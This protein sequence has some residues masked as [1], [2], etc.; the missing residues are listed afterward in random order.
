ML[1]LLTLA[2]A[3]LPASFD[4]GMPHT[5]PA[6]VLRPIAQSTGDKRAIA[7]ISTWLK[8]YRKGK[9]DLSTT[10][11]PRMG[12]RGPRRPGPG[13]R[14]NVPQGP[15][16]DD[17]LIVKHKLLP[18][19]HIRGMSYLI[20][21]DVLCR[22]AR[23]LDNVAAARAVL[24][25]AAVGLDTRVKYS[26]KM[27]PT[28]VRRVGESQLRR[29]RS[30]EVIAYLA[31]A[32]A[33]NPGGSG[34]YKTAM[35]AAALRA[36]GVKRSSVHRSVIVEQLKST[37]P[38]VRAAAANALGR[39]AEAYSIKPL[40]E[41]LPREGHPTVIIEILAAI[42]MIRTPL[43]ESSV[44]LV[45]MQMA[46][47]EAGRALGRADTWR[48]DLA[49]VDFLEKYRY[50]DSIPLLIQFLERWDKDPHKVKSGR[51]S[52]RLRFRVHEV[53]ASLTGARIPM[54]APE[55][56]REFW[57]ANQT[58]FKLPTPDK[59]EG[60]QD[61]KR[62]AGGFFNIPVQG[63]RIVFVIDRSGS[64][65]RPIQVTSRSGPTV[66]GGRGNR[67]SSLKITI[68]KREL[69]KA[70]QALPIDA[71]FNVIWYNH[72]VRQWKPKL[73]SA[74]KRNKTSFKRELDALNAVGNTNI[75]DSMKLALKMKSLVYGQHYDSNVDEVF[76]LSD[77]L[78][79]TGEVTNPNDILRIITET[80]KFSRVRINTVYLEENFG[81]MGGRGG[82]RGGFGGGGADL[83]RQLAE[84]NG[85]KFVRP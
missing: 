62:T 85:G 37:T 22:L 24:E 32:A 41:R 80:N 48:P 67:N 27:A 79:N 23:D 49:I 64:M 19:D 38:M 73:V 82:G 16:F 21:I 83:M 61:P 1:T 5:P 63:K 84:R 15:K 36:L 53:L 40:A 81:G 42:D 71:K 68:A 44:K 35:Q 72:E 26:S 34:T 13:A 29:F 65:N 77:G 52:A 78:P 43:P 74:S 58:T 2:G 55:R 8:I 17:Y 33:G 75:F 76:L 69:W 11:R 51:L 46:V 10:N 14:G 45:H 9:W 18:D 12:G 3:L 28:S 25:V 4:V 30:M 20:E 6:A 50:K 57:T 7:V 70:I 56:W 47:I 60:R 39:L 66:A 59:A 31:T 54:T